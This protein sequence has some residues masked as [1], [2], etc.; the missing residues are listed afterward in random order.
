VIEKDPAYA[1]GYFRLGLLYNLMGRRE[2]ALKNLEKA[3]ELDPKQMDALALA[4]GIYTKDKEYDKAI[5]ICERWKEKAKEN[6]TRLAMI[7]YM[8]GNI[9]LEKKD[10]EKARHHFE[11]AILTDANVL[12]VYVALAKLYI[13]EE[14]IEGAISQ[15]KAILE[16]NP[17]SLAGYMGLGTIYDQQGNGKKAE[18]NYRKAL[19]IKSDFAPAANNLA[20]N[21]LEREGNIDEAL[22][23]AQIAKEQMPKNPSVM[24]TLGWVYYRKGSYLNAIAEFQDSLALKPENPIINYHLGMAYFKNNQHDAARESLEK[25]LNIDQNF[26][27]SEEARRVLKEINASSESS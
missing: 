18:E 20:W 17:Y 22:G 16:K 12:A 8:Q 3:L 2:D 19:A 5:R 21:L 6:P 25:A 9:S 23:F 1:P 13:Q 10:A 14:N 4:A 26:K 24:D 7:E 27:G 15:Y 11:K